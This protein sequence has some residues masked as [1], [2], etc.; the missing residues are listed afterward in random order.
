MRSTAERRLT[1]LR[2]LQSSSCAATCA[3]AHSS[4]SLL[5]ICTHAQ[6]RPANEQWPHARAR[7][8]ATSTPRGSRAAPLPMG[9]MR[10]ADRAPLNPC[11]QEACDSCRGVHASIACAFRACQSLRR[12]P[13]AS[14]SERAECSAALAGAG[15]RAGVRACVCRRTSST[16][17]GSSNSS[18]A[19]A[20]D[21]VG[22]A[23]AA[24]P[25]RAPATPAGD[26]TGDAA[27]AAAAAAATGA[28][29]AIGGD[30]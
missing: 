6:T 3:A 11:S 14:L 2:A 20:A 18:S 25:P 15:A 9:R 29:G 4:T 30:A 24:L 10:L 19:A 17:C 5:T 16:L 1:D 21:D 27:A 13:S 23:D 12:V 7:V 28:G 8:P 22:L 26:S